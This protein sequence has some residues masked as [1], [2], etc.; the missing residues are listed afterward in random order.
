AAFLLFGLCIAYNGFQVLFILNNIVTEINQVDIMK[1]I[2]WKSDFGDKLKSGVHF[3]LCPVEHIV[4]LI[5]GKKVSC[6]AKRIASVAIEGM[7]VRTGKFQVVFHW[8][9]EDVLIAIVPSESKR[10]G[11]V[12]SLVLNLSNAR[13]KFFVT[14]NDC[15]VLFCY[16]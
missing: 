1:A 12:R 15:H 13:K 3:R 2:V 5:P 8:F 10:V 14:C 16:K 9:P 6:A 7:P 4:C 11:R